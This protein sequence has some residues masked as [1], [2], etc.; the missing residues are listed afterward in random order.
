[1]SQN[2]SQHRKNLIELLKIQD[3]RAQNRLIELYWDTLY[4]FFFT[5][6]KLHYTADDLTVLTFS[7]AMAKFDTFDEERDLTA[8]LMAIAR[9]TLID[10][11][12]SKNVLLTDELSTHL[13]TACDAA[14]T[15]EEQL[16]SSQQMHTVLSIIAEM[17]ERY[18]NIIELRFLED[19]SIR[20]IA[21]KLNITESNVKVR[22]MRAKN[23]LTELLEKHLK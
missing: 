13:D 21:E 22:I 1:M 11:Y 15:P 7:K 6:T 23:I 17:D 14:P 18:R 10:Y 2:F 12:R 4:G 20:E 8:W 19:N 5:N 16:I 9:N 3:P